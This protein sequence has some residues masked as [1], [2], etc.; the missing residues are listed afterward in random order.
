MAVRIAPLHRAACDPLTRLAAKAH[1]QSIGN[2]RAAVG[3][4]ADL[5]LA[6]QVGDTEEGGE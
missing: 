2:D 6:D 1:E 3:I 5:G 4:D